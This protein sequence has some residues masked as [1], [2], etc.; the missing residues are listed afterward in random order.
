MI[1]LY[2][3]KSAVFATGSK[4]MQSRMEQNIREVAVIA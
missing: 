4:E 2:A 1:K 3:Q